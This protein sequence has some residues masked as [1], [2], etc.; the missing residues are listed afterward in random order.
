LTCCCAAEIALQFLDLER[1][2]VERVVRDVCV[3]CD[4]RFR[5]GVVIGCSWSRSPGQ[6]GAVVRFPVDKLQGKVDSEFELLASY[7]RALAR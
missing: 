1:D 2:C 5:P 3:C 6:S 4:I 7:V